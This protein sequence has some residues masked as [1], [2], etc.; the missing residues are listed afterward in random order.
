MCFAPGPFQ[1][2]IRTPV[3]IS[4]NCGI[5]QN[6]CNCNL[7]EGEL[8][9]IIISALPIIKAHG[10]ETQFPASLI[11]V[12]HGGE[13]SASS[14]YHFIPRERAPRSQLNRRLGRPQNWLQPL[15]HLNLLCAELAILLWHPPLAYYFLFSEVFHRLLALKKGELLQ[16]CLRHRKLNELQFVNSILKYN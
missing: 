11:P 4:F 10:V 15:L 12:L 3:I 8:V 16:N 1:V 6:T 14:P 13:C 5:I 2:L 7:H 9:P